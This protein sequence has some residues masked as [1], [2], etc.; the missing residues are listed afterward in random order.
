MSDVRKK[1]KIYDI[2]PNMEYKNTHLMKD[3]CLL[4]YI[5]AKNMVMSW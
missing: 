3:C 2:A 5:Y 4:P 1:K